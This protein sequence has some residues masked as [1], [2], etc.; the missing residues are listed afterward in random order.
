MNEKTN[1][2]INNTKKVFSHIVRNIDRYLCFILGCIFMFI[3]LF[4]FL[5]LRGYIV[6]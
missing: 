4:F 1:K 5:G 2:I 6:S 3:A